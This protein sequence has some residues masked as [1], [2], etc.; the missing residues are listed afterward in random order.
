MLAELPPEATTGAD[1]GRGEGQR[2]LGLS[3]LTPDV[4]QK[5]GLERLH[6]ERWLPRYVRA[7]RQNPH[8]VLGLKTYQGRAATEQSDRWLQQA[9]RVEDELRGG[10]ARESRVLG[11]RARA[12]ATDRLGPAEAAQCT[13][14]HARSIRPLLAHPDPASASPHRREK[15][16]S[17]QANGQTARLRHRRDGRPP[18][19][20]RRSRL[21]NPRSRLRK[22]S[23]SHQGLHVGWKHGAPG[24]VIN[25]EVGA[26]KMSK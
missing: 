14:R 20:K 13:P 8:G 19:T 10:D 26:P 17:Q 12:D 2:G 11:K 21:A 16:T 22:A 4:A 18:Q 7:A 1:A 23:D 24:D 5:L 15:Q 6:E 25:D 9:C 3:T